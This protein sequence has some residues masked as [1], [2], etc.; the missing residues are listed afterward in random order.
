MPIVDSISAALDCVTL[1]LSYPLRLMATALS[2]RMLRLFGYP[3]FAERTLITLGEDR[4]I[5]V[6]DACGGI[7]QLFALII[8]GFA[9][10]RIMQSSWPWQLFHWATILP[11]LV[12]ANTVR[13][14][15]T[16]MLLDKFGPVVLENACHRALGWAQTVFSVFLLWLFGAGIRYASK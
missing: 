8:V 2:V 15:L 5:A 14:L 7:D 13:L 1:A 11:S 9:F 10:A 3:V 12:L 16:V 6:T 4:A